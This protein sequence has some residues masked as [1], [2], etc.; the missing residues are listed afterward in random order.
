MKANIKRQLAVIWTN[1]PPYRYVPQSTGNGASWRVF[2]RKAQKFLK[3]KEVAKL[4]FAD[5]IE[6]ILD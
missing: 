3:D 2:D 1:D 4:S 5:C 6:K